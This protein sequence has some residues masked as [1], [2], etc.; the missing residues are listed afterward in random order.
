MTD[1]KN[2]LTMLKIFELDGI[3]YEI[4]C[5][6]N[7]IRTLHE[8]LEY[9]GYDSAQYSN[10]AWGIYLMLDASLK[11]MRHIIEELVKVEGR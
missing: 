6:A 8:A 4:E 2:D 3:H 7:L 1:K 9:G 10:S 11:K 5:S